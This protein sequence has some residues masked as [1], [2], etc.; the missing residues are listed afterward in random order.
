MAAVIGRRFPEFDEYTLRNSSC[1]E[2][3]T[4]CRPG[5]LFSGRHLY[6]CRMSNDTVSTLNDKYL[7]LF[8]LPL[9]VI[10]VLLAQMPF[11]FP[12]RWDLFCRYFFI[13]LIFTVLI[14]EVARLILLRVRRRFP[15][16]EQ[17]KQRILWMLFNF[18]V[19]I[20][21]GQ[22]ILSKMMLGFR[23]AET[24]EP[25]WTVWLVNFASSLFFIVLLSSIYEAA[26][27]FGQYKT[28]LQLAEELKKRQA[29]TSLD[30]LKNRV[31]PHFL[32]NSLTTLSALIGEDARL[33][34]RFVDE[35]SKVYR[36]LLRTGRQP[37]VAVGEE[38]QFAESYV[39]LLK[40]R[41]EEGAFSLEVK[42]GGDLKS[43]PDSE[44]MLPTLTLQNALDYL[45]RTQ[46]LPL[47]ISVDAM[48]SEICIACAYRPK[49]LSFDT[50]DNDW[51][52]LAAHGAK[53][54]ARSGQLT[55]QVP[56]TQN[57]PVK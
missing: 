10:A 11:Y 46:H 1:T 45:V 37:T 20:G 56:F 9:S 36:Y 16:L 29:K 18:V 15:N 26:Y 38:L 28:S 21:I 54:E 6:I 7:R 35:L 17:T 48:G 43:L 52:Y 30:A 2:N 47:H 53:Q 57:K 24:T 19:V 34:E 27:F 8:G 32:F 42:S 22:G 40:N 3:N 41:F 25:F 55:I 31:N 44:Q 39:F 13:S 50:P 12:G 51:R 14:W 49:S 4:S 33:A 23:W 5:F